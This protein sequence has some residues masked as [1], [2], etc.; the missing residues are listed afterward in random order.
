MPF[1]VSLERYAQEL[2]Q[3]RSDFTLSDLL[4]YAFGKEHD[5]QKTWQQNMS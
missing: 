5:R 3:T 1:S 4:N 2:L